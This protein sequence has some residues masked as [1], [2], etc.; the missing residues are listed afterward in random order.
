MERSSEEG[1]PSVSHPKVGGANCSVPQ[2]KLSQ[3]ELES[4]TIVGRMLTKCLL[5]QE[6]S[7]CQLVKAS[8]L[9][10]WKTVDNCFLHSYKSSL[11]Q[12]PWHQHRRS[13]KDRVC[14]HP[15]LF[16]S[17]YHIR[18]K[19]S[20]KIPRLCSNDIVLRSDSLAVSCNTELKLLLNKFSGPDFRFS[21]VSSSVVEP[22]NGPLT[23][24]QGS[25]L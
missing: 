20:S 24:E 16:P 7:G 4:S 8:L 9:R 10:G 11:F 21:Q 15:Q 25:L 2:T 3:A 18:G 17:P 6:V 23:L 13:H 12:G 22:S 19:K 14:T 1:S 5:E